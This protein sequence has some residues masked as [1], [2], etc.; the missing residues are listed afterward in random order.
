MTS[1]QVEEQQKYRACHAHP[2]QLRPGPDLLLYELRLAADPTAVA[3][4]ARSHSP[5]G[6]VL[7]VQKSKCLHPSRETTSS[8]EPLPPEDEHRDTERQHAQRGGE[9]D[10]EIMA[11]LSG[12]IA[13][14]YYRSTE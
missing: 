9:L 11:L 2:P 8:F 12:G 1:N 10:S 6:P 5:V 13:R 4:A 7:T 14:C 3:Q